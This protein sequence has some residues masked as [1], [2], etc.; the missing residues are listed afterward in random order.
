M[1][2][3]FPSSPTPGTVFTPAGGPTWQW[4]GT[5]WLL[6]PAAAVPTLTAE[7][8]NRILN[9]AMQISQENGITAVGQRLSRRS[10]MLDFTSSSTITSARAVSP[11]TGRS[12]RPT[13]SRVLLLR[14]IHR[15]RRRNT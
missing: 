15:L 8:R 11:A 1:A 7:S 6:V 4:D 13:M 5:T 12:P 14:R 2:F 10:V 9:G 3:D